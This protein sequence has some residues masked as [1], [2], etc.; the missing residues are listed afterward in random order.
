MPEWTECSTV[1]N[2][3]NTSPTASHSFRLLR[4]IITHVHTLHAYCQ[5]F[6]SHR[7]EIA[8]CFNYIGLQQQM[9]H[10]A[11]PQSNAA[12]HYGDL[13][14]HT[15]V[16]LITRHVPRELVCAGRCATFHSASK[17]PAYLINLPA[18]LLPLPTH[19]HTHSRHMLL[20]YYAHFRD[21]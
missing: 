2:N 6:D 12:T 15:L 13:L 3:T 16:P 9:K 14:P 19:T 7:N 17:E 20:N 21:C 8:S 1:R 5:Y 18:G 10:I 4:V 11:Q